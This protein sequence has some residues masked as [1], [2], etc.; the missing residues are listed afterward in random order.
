M[1]PSLREYYLIRPGYSFEEYIDEIEPDWADNLSI[2]ATA[3]CFNINIIIYSSMC[4]Y[5]WLLDRESESVR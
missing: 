3:D 1:R 4:Q 5:S 2:F